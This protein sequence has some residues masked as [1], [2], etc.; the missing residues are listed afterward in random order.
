MAVYKRGDVYWYSFI[1]ASQRVQESSKS[2]SKTVAREAEKQRRRQL[3][4]GI[5]GL[6]SN[7]DTRIR[8]I[9]DIAAEYLIYYRLRH[10]GVA[11]A[12][13]AIGRVVRLLGDRMAV[14]IGEAIVKD[15]QSNRLREKAAP[16]SINDEVGFLLRLLAD[17]SDVLRVRLKKNKVLKVEVPPTIGATIQ[18][19]L[20][21]HR[22]RYVKKFGETRP[23]MVRVSLRTSAAIRS[24]PA[25]DD[26]ENSVGECSQ[27]RES[28]RPLARCPTHAHYGT[29]G[30]GRGRRDN[31]G[32]CRARFEANVTRYSHLRMD[33]KRRALDAVAARNRKTEPT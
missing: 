3:E 19:A 24:D 20:E 11:F 6:T 18:D 29:G 15:Y 4:A 14:E 28:L 10:R 13:Y 22:E 23:G 9:K 32:D 12:E 31:H 30:N 17:S 1:F 25:C 16:K 27:G 8:T 21:R 33:A 2:K 5:N 7:R 26:A